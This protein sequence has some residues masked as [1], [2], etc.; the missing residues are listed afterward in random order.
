MRRE[1][2]L[3]G[4]ADRFRQLTVMVYHPVN[5]ATFRNDLDYY[6]EWNYKTVTMR[7][8]WEHLE[9][10]STLPDKPLWIT[11]DDGLPTQY[12]AAEELKNR[13][14]IGIFYIATG[15]IDGT[16]TQAQGGFAEA[17]PLTWAQIQ[18]MHAWGHDI[19]SHTKSHI[20]LGD[21]VEATVKAEFTDSKARI[22]AQVPGTL[23]EHIAYPYGSW[24]DDTEVWLEEA[25]CKL[26]RAVRIDRDGR[27]PGPNMGRDSIATTAH[28]R[29]GI[30]CAGAN[31]GDVQRPNFFREI[32]HEPEWCPDYG[33]EGG[34]KGWSLGSGFSVDSNA[35]NAHSGTKSLTCMQG[36]ST[37]SSR[38]F[39]V[40]PIGPFNRLQISGWIR[41]TLPAG[42]YAKVQLQTLKVDGTV[43]GVNIDIGTVTGPVGW[44]KFTYEYVGLEHDRNALLFLAVQGNAAPSGQA[45]FDDISVKVENA[46][47]ALSV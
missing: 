7:D 41:S 25:G 9:G 2:P 15:W 10:I 45:W 40:M 27:Y 39:R 4:A 46:P 12:T 44:T 5:M 35:A 29:F 23:V 20:P 47:S 31:F 6:Q 34:A 33:F 11:F 19:Q 32:G 36:T 17:T 1:I 38:P 30:P 18:Q 26:G 43:N 22:E 37:V 16:V 13:G 3:R 28:R 8:V 21:Q 14:M 24:N 42:S